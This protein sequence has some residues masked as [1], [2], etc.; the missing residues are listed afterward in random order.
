MLMLFLL[1]L[2]KY[3]IFNYVVKKSLKK[4]NLNLFGQIKNLLF[5]LKKCLNFLKTTALEF[6][7]PIQI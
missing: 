5:S 3:Q 2:K 1:N 7:M 6:I 4:E